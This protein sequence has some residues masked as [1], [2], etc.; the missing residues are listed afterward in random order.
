MNSFRIVCWFLLCCALPLAAQTIRS[1]S[2]FNRDVAKTAQPQI[3]ELVISPEIISELH[4]KPNFATTI[5]MPEPITNVV[6]GAPTLFDAE[7][8]DHAPELVV[9]KPLTEHPATSNLWIATRSGQHVSLKLL[10]DGD[11]S[12]AGPVDYVLIYRKSHDFLIASDDPADAAIA[13]QS[14]GA[15]QP[16]LFGTA[17]ASQQRIASLFWNTQRDAKSLLKITVSIGS[18]INDGDSTIVAFSVLNQSKQWVEVPL[19]KSLLMLWR[20]MT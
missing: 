14:L 2:S 11:A 13:D 6:L 7:H 19:Q 3:S 17:F 5:L 12:P 1:G 20:A 9:V 18:V 15:R 16:S 4:L 10:N 8:S